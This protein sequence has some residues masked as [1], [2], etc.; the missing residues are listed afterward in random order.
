MTEEPH[1]RQNSA[2]D[3]HAIRLSA[4]PLFHVN[5]TRR[6]AAIG[7]TPAMHCS[8]G[9]MCTASIPLPQTNTYRPP[10]PLPEEQ[11]ST[12][13]F[14]KL[15]HLASSP[16]ADSTCPFTAE[17]ARGFIRCPSCRKKRFNCALFFWPPR[18]SL[19]RVPQ[20]GHQHILRLP[21]QWLY[22]QLRMIFPMSTTW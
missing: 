7:E 4:I 10:W 15:P 3:V 21:R 9:S 8:V 14:S 22:H 13:D 2:D 16:T 18:P 11:Y 20:P 1:G 6:V 17:P 19:L 5:K 12:T